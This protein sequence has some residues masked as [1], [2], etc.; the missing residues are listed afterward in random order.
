MGLFGFGKK[1]NEGGIMDAINIGDVKNYLIYKWRPKGQEA[2]S[3]NKENA[4][5]T[6]SSLLVNEGQAAIFIYPNSGGKSDVRLGYCNGTIDTGNMP[7]LA[8]IIGAAYAGGTPFQAQVYF[9]TL[10]EGG[11]QVHFTVPFFTVRP[12]QREYSMFTIEMAVDGTLT[13][14]AAPT[15][16][17]M[18]QLYMFQKQNG[19]TTLN[20]EDFRIETTKEA[21]RKVFR[22]WGGKDTTMDEVEQR[23]EAMVTSSIKGTFSKIPEGVFVLQ[24]NEMIEEWSRLIYQKIYKDLRDSL[25][26]WPT[27]LDITDIRFNEGS[28][29]YQ[30]LKDLTSRQAYNISMQNQANVLSQLAT[31]A[32]V[33]NGA[34]ARQAEIQM[35]H[36]EDM[37]ARM[38]EE[39]QYAQ[40]AQTDSTMHRTDLATEQ[41]YLGAHTVNVQGEVMRT[42]MENIG[43]MSSMDM[44]NGG[45]NPAGMMMGMG[46]ATGMAGQM[47]Q[48]MG[49]MG[50]AFNNQVAQ[51]GAPTPPPM[52]GQM[53]PAPP[54]PQAAAYFVLINNQ[55]AGP[56]DTNTLRQMAAAGQITMQTQ[57]WTQGMPQW[58]AISAVPALAVLF[59]APP[60]PPMP[61]SVPPPP[62]VL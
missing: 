39:A 12:S 6:G 45:M 54:T 8:N 13:F 53:P 4:I 51:A 15:D 47:G 36:Q 31:D 35:D 22:Q 52:P 18:E 9:I 7:V 48:M 41:A 50:N 2:N 28:E 56:F 49:N 26:I 3:T 33:R 16:M 14:A 44:G 29:D 57:V 11:M 17:Q 21:A 58:A 43:N 10:N 61:G 1:T 59:Q 32:A 25:G 19:M 46:M 24:A 23:I 27:R 40:H 55:Q 62:P 30:H 38:R 37:L 60:T 34:V 20:F 42:G 5:R